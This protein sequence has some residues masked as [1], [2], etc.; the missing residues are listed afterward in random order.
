M[1]R[2]DTDS[3]TIV[4]LW[5]GVAGTALGVVGIGLTLYSFFQDKPSIIVLTGS[6]WAAAVLCSI[7]S[8]WLGT[9]LVKLLSSQADEL[10]RQ[11]QEIGILKEQLA[12][13]IMEKQRLITIS[14]FLSSKSLRQVTRKPSSAT[15][16]D[17]I[18]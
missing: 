1:K 13:A 4:G 15:E 14:E 3:A 7:T 8:G 5:V 2:L 16:G 12:E 10:S 17:P 9:K 11:A 6:G 18:K